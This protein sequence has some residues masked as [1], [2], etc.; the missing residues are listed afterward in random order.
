MALTIEQLQAQRDQAILAMASPEKVEFKD[1]AV[2]NRAP[3]DLLTTIYRLDKEIAQLRSPQDK[4]F[5]IQTKR[6]IE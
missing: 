5:V 2:T 4:T 1:R 6:G 3:G